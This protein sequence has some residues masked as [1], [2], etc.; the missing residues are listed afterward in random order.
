VGRFLQQV[1]KQHKGLGLTNRT[2]QA[3]SWAQRIVQLAEW[4]KVEGEGVQWVGAYQAKPEAA[5]IVAPCVEGRT[6]SGSFAG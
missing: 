2:W 6:S 1:K 3:C 4:S 5:I